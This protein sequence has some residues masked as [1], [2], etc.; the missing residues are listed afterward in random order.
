MLVV[1]PLGLLASYGVY[2]RAVVTSPLVIH[3]INHES[4]FK[5][6]ISSP[7]WIAL[8]AKLAAELRVDKATLQSLISLPVAQSNIATSPSVLLAGQC[9]S[10]LPLPLSHLGIQKFNTAFVLVQELVTVAELPAGRVVVVQIA[11]VAH[12]QVSHLAH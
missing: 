4:L 9:T 1:Y 12:A 11:T 7:G 8:E 2:P 5:S 6:E 10:Q 3:V